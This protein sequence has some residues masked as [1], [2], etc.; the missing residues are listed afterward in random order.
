MKDFVDL[1]DYSK[2]INDSR[3]FEEKQIFIDS[4][5]HFNH[6]ISSYSIKDNNIIISFYKNEVEVISYTKDFEICILNRMKNEASTYYNGIKYDKKDDMDKI[7]F[8]GG[9]AV[10]WYAAMTLYLASG[11]IGLGITYGAIGTIWFLQALPGIINLVTN[12]KIL[13]EKKKFKLYMNMEEKLA[14][15]D[16]LNTGIQ[17]SKTKNTSNTKLNIN[18]YKKFSIKE[19]ETLNKNLDTIEENNYFLEDNNKTLKKTRHI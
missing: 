6:R 7:M 5:G 9:P 1:V 18:T 12:K 3:S 14:R 19:L 15:L 16:N 11:K 4:L 17:I 13:K 8:K 2:I 10:M